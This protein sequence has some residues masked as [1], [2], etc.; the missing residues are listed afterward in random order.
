MKV[1]SVRVTIA[2]PGDLSREIELELHVNPRPTLCWIPREVV[3]KLSLPMLPR[4]TFVLSSG[5]M[6][7]R[8]IATAFIRVQGAL[9]FT[10]VVV[11]E[12]GDTPVL[13]M[14]ALECLCF[15]FDEATGRLVPQPFL[16]MEAS[17]QV[18]AGSNCL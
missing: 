8:E 15:R 7:E 14:V 5:G 13:G 2:H 17:A 4:R 6:V 10:S 16:A 3:E 12:P 18:S 11:A 1:F 9:T